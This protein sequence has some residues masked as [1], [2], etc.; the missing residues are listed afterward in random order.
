MLRFEHPGYLALLAVL[1]LIVVLSFRSL[2]GLG[3]VRRWLAISIRCVV[4]TLMIFALA[5]AQRAKTTNKL[6]TVFLLDRSASMP[7]VMQQAAFDFIKIATTGLRPD[8]QV[9]VLAFDGVSTVEQLPMGALGIERITDPV[10]PERTDL[11]GAARLALALF[12]SD[13][14][15]RVVLL[16]DGNENAG[17]VL[18]EAERF[19]AAGIPIDIVPIDYERTNEVLIERLKTPQFADLDQEINLQVVLRATQPATGRVLIYHGEE[20]IDLDADSPEAGFPVALK[21]GPERIV[22]PLPLKTLGA[23][24]FTA[25]FVPDR[26]QADAVPANNEGRSFTI[27]SGP[28]RVLIV[29]SS[30]D[31][32]SPTPDA[33]YIRRALESEKI[34]VDVQAAGAPQLDQ[35]RLLEYSLVILSNVSAGDFTDAEKQG[36]AI[37]VRD[38]GGGLVMVGGDE[39]FGAGGWMGSPVEEIMPVSF[40]VK[41][42]K[43]IPKGA[44][45]LVMHACEIPQGN[46]W[47]ERVAIESVKT[48]SSRDLVGVVAWQW[49]GMDQDHWVVKLQEVG[50]KAAIIARIKQMTMGDMPAFDPPMRTAVNALAA[51]EDA[52]AKHMIIV[53]DFDP[54]DPD[55]DVIKKMKDNGITCSTVAIG[56]GG[57]MIDEFKAR[58]IAERTGGKFYKTDDF[59]KLPQIFIKES[60]IVRRAL[61]NEAPFS[62]RLVNAIS[63]VVAGLGGL[64]LP[65][66]GGMV[67]TTPKPLADV[68]II[69]KSDEGDDPVLAHWQVGLGK[70]V[71]FT[72]GM[73]TRWGEEWTEWPRFAKVWAQIARWAGR[74]SETPAFDVTTTVQG[75]RARVQVD[76]VDKNARAVDFLEI[77]GTLVDAGNESRPLR[78]IQTGPGRYEAEY[79]ARNAGNYIV[80]LAYRSRAGGES[81]QGSLRTGVSVAYSAEYAELLPNHALLEQVRALSGG[82]LLTTLTEGQPLD[83]AAAGKAFDRVGLDRAEARTSIWEDLIRLMLVLFLLDVAIRRIAINPMELLRNGRRYL[84]DLAGRG[85]PRGQA[86]AVL[87]TLKGTR[88]RARQ[89]TQ[90]RPRAPLPETQQRE[91]KATEDL[92]KALGGATSQDAPVVARPTGKKP[93]QGQAD[94]TSRLREAKKRAREDMEKEE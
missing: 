27:V 89:E 40:D 61:I 93:P 45:C 47:G 76:A 37:Y 10:T 62:P 81:L 38:L 52:A 18:A 59:S 64:A 24:R 13:A 54:A 75:G 29:A 15:K 32:E 50:D 82:R 31:L 23:H 30:R 83:R 77:A 5:G 91:A 56:Y 28:G 22:I 39:S 12:P 69:K 85:Q 58:R 63:P 67:L 21:G 60:R 41:N 78:L 86:E 48:L 25:K 7:Q 53:S 11:A 35:V 6:A 73:W 4:I 44:L 19:K 16:S 66:L 20:L 70:T 65:Q 90:A 71:A 80:N 9:G 55:E 14:A 43:Q 33:L 94:Y 92:S 84:A 8:D 51:R 17:A 74:E 49:M 68:P 57:H 79:D 42:K 36:L 1:P 87:T 34:A 72:S 46:Y 2:A 26:V 88:E 3:P